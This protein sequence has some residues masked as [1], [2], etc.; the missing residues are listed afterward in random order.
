MLLKLGYASIATTYTGF[1]LGFLNNW[2][3]NESV[4]QAIE[5]LITT[6]SALGLVYVFLM[7]SRLV[8]LNTK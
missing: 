2:H 6:G 7:F 3:H 8:Y 4:A 5:I 1:A